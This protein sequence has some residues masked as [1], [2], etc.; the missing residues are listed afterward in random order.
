[1]QVKV[2]N[3]LIYSPK[4]MEDACIPGVFLLEVESPFTFEPIP[5][6]FHFRVFVLFFVV[7]L[8]AIDAVEELHTLVDQLVFQK[9][10]S[11]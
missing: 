11:V 10:A 4:H 3:L 1:M 8:A 9:T 5:L 7:F 2:N 6:R